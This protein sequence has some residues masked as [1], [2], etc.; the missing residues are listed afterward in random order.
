MRSL[1]QAHL[2]YTMKIGIQLCPNTKPV[3]IYT[4]TQLI[5][6]IP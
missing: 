5:G 4:M 1:N 3:V 2:D 6:D